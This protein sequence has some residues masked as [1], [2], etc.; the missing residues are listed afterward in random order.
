MVDQTQ[1]ISWT[2]RRAWEG[3]ITAGHFGISGNPGITV[4]VRDA[5]G[6]ATLMTGGNNPAALAAAVRTQLGLALPDKPAA[7]SHG[8]YHIVWNGPG[9]WL[10]LSE[11]RDSFREMLTTLAGVAAIS[12]QSDSRIIFTL[13]GKHVRDV[14]AKGVMIDLHPKAFTE[15]AAALTSIAHMGITLW[16]GPDG[17]DGSIFNIAVPR[18]M[19]G[20][21]WSW[22]TASAAEFGCSVSVA[23]ASGL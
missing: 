13:S 18:S 19:A 8:Q 14:L 10:L 1:S 7:I 15:G 2:P 23:P 5:P 12:D 9:Q 4:T 22:F 3:V 11:T 20:S 16:R 17:T 21:F 6:I